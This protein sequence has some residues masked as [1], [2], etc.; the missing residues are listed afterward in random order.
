MD[1]SAQPVLSGQTPDPKAVAAKADQDAL[2][3]DPVEKLVDV[4]EEIE[5]QQED[6]QAMY[7]AGG[8]FKEQLE[9][10]VKD[11]RLASSEVSSGVQEHEVKEVEEI[12]ENPEIEPQVESH[13]EK[14]EK[15]PAQMQKLTDDYVAAVGLN[16][17]VQNKK[18]PL[19]LTDDQIKRGLHHE[20]WEAIRWLAEWCVRQAK[21]VR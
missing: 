11:R 18:P 21:M 13:L 12:P 17:S 8:H 6:F 20:V 2:T 7:N 5:E 19:P 4:V 14:I 15:D 10:I 3:Q 16:S 1:N 9:A